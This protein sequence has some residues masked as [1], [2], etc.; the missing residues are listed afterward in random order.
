MH[1]LSIGEKRIF[2]HTATPWPPM[3]NFISNSFFLVTYMIPKEMLN[4][5][6]TLKYLQWFGIIMSPQFLLLHFYTWNDVN[7]SWWL[8]ENCKRVAVKL[9][10]FTPGIVYLTLMPC[11][12]GQSDLTLLWKSRFQK[13]L[14]PSCASSLKPPLFYNCKQFGESWRRTVIAHA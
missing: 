3:S 12:A 14:L 10:N 4:F 9:A 7:L 5:I 2:H 1:R 8:Q 11:S 6:D 13:F